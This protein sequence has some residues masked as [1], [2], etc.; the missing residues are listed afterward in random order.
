MQAATSSL[1]D[2]IKEWG[3]HDVQNVKMDEAGKG[4]FFTG[5]IKGPNGH[6]GP[7]AVYWVPSNQGALAF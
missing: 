5:K 4:Y 6:L 1:I 7:R 3:Y 2:Y